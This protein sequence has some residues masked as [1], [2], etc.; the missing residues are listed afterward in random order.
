M[1]FGIL[2]MT[3]FSVGNHSS[4]AVYY[5]YDRMDPSPESLAGASDNPAAAR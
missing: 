5:R 1:P 3:H 4:T 2:D